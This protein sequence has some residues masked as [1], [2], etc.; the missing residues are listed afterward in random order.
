VPSFPEQ[1]PRLIFG[2]HRIV[3]SAAATFPFLR[4][5]APPAGVAYLHPPLDNRLFK[6]GD[7][8]SDATHGANMPA[9]IHKATRI[10]RTPYRSNFTTTLPELFPSMHI[11]AGFASMGVVH[12]ILCVVKIH[13]RFSVAADVTTLVRS[14]RVQ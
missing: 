3:L 11:H 2:S 1:S 12:L 8:L 7:W 6:P 5:T 10:G 14:S 9:V 4:A 13:Q